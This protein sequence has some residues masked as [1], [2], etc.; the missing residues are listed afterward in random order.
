[1]RAISPESA[2]RQGRKPTIWLLAGVLLLS[3]CA[4]PIKGLYPPEPDDEVKRVYVVR[5]NRHTGIA[6]R[7]E[8]IPPAVW[9]QIRDFP[10]VDYLEVSWGDADYYPA[11]EPTLGM[12]LKAVLLPTRSV[13]HV[14]GFDGSV[15]DYFPTSDIVEIALSQAG[16]ERLCRFIAETYALA[17]D[18][19]DMV[20]HGLYPN[21]RF[22]PARP[23]FHLFRTC[24][25]WVTQALRAAGCPVTPF[26]AITAGNVI[27]QVSKFGTVVRR[28]Q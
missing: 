23:T 1:M 18:S 21:S 19:A 10:N 26:Y 8:D 14:G 22:Y 3:A 12:G 2:P 13:L 20:Q 5:Q 11:P 4:G 25:T 28:R 16:F 27:Y 7:R 9:P 24:N 15:E 6:L 17:D